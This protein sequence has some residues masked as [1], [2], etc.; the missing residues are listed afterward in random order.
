MSPG[1]LHHHLLAEAREIKAKAKAAKWIFMVE[2][3]RFA[4]TRVGFVFLAKEIMGKDMPKSE[5]ECV[6]CGRPVR[7]S[8]VELS[9]K[10]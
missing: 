7:G 10:N 1:A 6:T 8:C 4:S 3:F 5:S 2:W 9:R